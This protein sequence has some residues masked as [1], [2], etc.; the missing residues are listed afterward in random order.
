MPGLADDLL[1]F[2]GPLLSMVQAASGMFIAVLVT[3]RIASRLGVA[4]KERVRWWLLVAVAVLVAVPM[5]M[6]GRV[7]FHLGWP[8]WVYYTITLPLAMIVPKVA[9][10]F[11]WLEWAVYVV[12]ATATGAT[13]HVVFSLFIGYG[14]Y[15]PFWRINPLWK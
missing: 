2:H 4:S 9:F 5:V 15:M 8:G 7:G 3:K 11:R 6:L 1:T 13:T 14:N 10:G 12:V